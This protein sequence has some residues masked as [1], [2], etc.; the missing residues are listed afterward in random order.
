MATPTGT[1]RGRGVSVL[2]HWASEDSEALNDVIEEFHRRS[3]E[4]VDSESLPISTLRLNVKGRILSEDPPDVWS[5]WPGKNLAPVVEAGAIADI[6]DVWTDGGMVD[7]YADGPTEAARFD[8]RFYCVPLDIYRINNLYYNVDLVAEAGVD[9][10]SIGGPDAFVALLERLD[11]ELSVAPIQIG[12]RDPFGVLQLWETFL[13]AHGG[14]STYRALLDGGV[15]AHRDAVRSATESLEAVLG[16]L[17]SDAHF[18]ASED[19]DNRFARG[20]SVFLHNGTWAVGRISATEGFTFGRDWEHE[21]FPGTDGQ[22][23]MNMNSLVPAAQAADDEAVTEFLRFAGSSDGLEIFNAEVG[24][25]PP[26][27]DVPLDS[28]HPLTQRLT[29]ESERADNLPSMC[30]GLGVDPDVL[31]ELKSVTASHL[32][33]RDVAET[34]RRFAEALSEAGS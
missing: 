1:V 12:A 22:F 19:A 16:V 24:A 27:E 7:N 28:L 18:V 25:V 5:D 20:E 11:D 17:P 32:A 21:P 31:V 15:G 8:G 23:L 26:R 2:Q 3:G 33:D 10:G 13:L 29:R 6:T 4:R 9:V 30:H 14:A 34:T